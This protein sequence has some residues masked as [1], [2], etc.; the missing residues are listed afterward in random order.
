MQEPTT[1]TAL[2]T[3]ANKGIGFEIARQLAKAG[4][5]V[6]L[7][8]RNVAAGQ[9]AVNTLRDEGLD[10]NLV[11]L[12]LTNPEIVAAAAAVIKAG[13]G[14]LDVL[15]N[16]A[17]IAD[18][19]D[20]PPGVVDAALVR[21][22]FET[23]FFGTLAVTQAM[24]PLLRESSAPRVVN[25]VSPLGSL[26]L[27]S[28]PEWSFGGVKLLGYNGSKA[29]VNMLT[30]QLAHEFRHTNMKVNSV[31]PGST[32]TSINGFLGGQT[33]AEAATEPVR[34]ALLPDDGPSG[35]FFSADGPR[36]W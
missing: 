3:G 5:R 29:A 18:I 22:T 26:T 2:V 12:D 32:A 13:G 15:V 19:A 23:N 16:N 1:K 31:D 4:L 36:P 7:G 8:A 20:G 17:A 33:A 30:V 28:D 21:R 9:A 34:L 10:V 25:L 24:L 35:G 11:E 27:N 14:G 6:Y